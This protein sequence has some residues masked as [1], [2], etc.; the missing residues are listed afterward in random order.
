MAG[1]TGWPN[2]DPTGLLAGPVGTQCGV[3]LVHLHPSATDHS[4]AEVANT[5]PTSRYR[6]L[7][8]G[9]LVSYEHSLP[10]FLTYTSED[11]EL[12]FVQINQGVLGLASRL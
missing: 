10:L 1:R 5:A 4:E 6:S 8:T 9:A 2:A 3:G 7:L 12:M 11:C